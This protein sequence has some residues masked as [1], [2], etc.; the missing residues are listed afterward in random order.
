MRA[1]EIIITQDDVTRLSAGLQK[2]I[3]HSVE[4]LRK[5]EKIALLYNKND[6]FWLAFSGGKD[7]QCLY[8]VAKLAGV[9]FK[10]HMSLTSID[11]PDVIRFVRTQY[12]SVDMMKPFVSIYQRAIQK[13]IVPTKRVRWCCADFK[14]T[15]GAGNVT[16]IGIRAS[17]SSRRARRHEVETRTHKFSGNIDEFSDWQKEQIAKKLKKGRKAKINE[18]EFSVKSDNEVRC[19]Y[20]KD[21]ILVSPIFEWSDSDVWEFLN[22]LNIPHCNLYDE[23]FTRI[24]CILC[25]M[26]QRKQKEKE[27]A[28]WPHVKRNWIKAI[29]AIR[30]GG[31]YKTRVFVLGHSCPPNRSENKQRPPGG[32]SDSHAS[33]GDGAWQDDEDEIAENI[34]EWWISGKAYAQW[35][36][37]KFEQ[38][39]L[40]FGK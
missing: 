6:G 34:F 36:S 10:A 11:P 27:I 32:F 15:A 35:Y 12:P 13:R 29:K 1:E 30:A 24:G 5:A 14:E 20:G 8:H 22:V 16:L 7:S 33:N 28:R 26:S 25:P 37:E 39:K 21:S 9:K 19:I 40:D 4:L 3:V 31:G 2:K 38:L 23:G 18:D 17:E